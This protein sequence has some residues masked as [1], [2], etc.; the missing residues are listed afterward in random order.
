MRYGI[1]NRFL[2]ERFEHEVR[3]AQ[4]ARISQDGSLSDCAD[5]DYLG[6]GIQG[7][8]L[9]QGVDAVAL[10][11]YEIERCSGGAQ[12]CKEIDS[13]LAVSR[14]ADDCSPDAACGI[15]DFGAKN[16]GIISYE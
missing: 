15:L 5:D 10:G 13:L 8:D 4:I 9:A 1:D 7:K 14:F 3:R 16:G 12:L 2:R 11:H 6:I